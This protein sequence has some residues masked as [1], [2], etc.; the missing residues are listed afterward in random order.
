MMW[1]TL[2]IPTIIVDTHARDTWKHAD[3]FGQVRRFMEKNL[4]QTSQYAGIKI[5]HKGDL[6]DQSKVKRRAVLCSILP[7][8]NHKQLKSLLVGLKLTANQDRQ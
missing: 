1:L 7:T 3:N 8:I 2:F 5:E 6:N 4:L